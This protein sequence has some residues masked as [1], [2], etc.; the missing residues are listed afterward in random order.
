MKYLCLVYR[1]EKIVEA[2]SQ[3]EFAAFVG[4][5]SAY[6]AMLRESGHGILSQGLQSVQ[7]AT[8]VRVRSGK[9]YTTDGP[10]AETK[11]QLGGFSS[12]APGIWTKPSSWRPRSR[13]RAWGASR[14]GRSGR[15]SSRSRDPVGGIVGGRGS[16]V[17]GSLTDRS[18]LDKVWPSARPLP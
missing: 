13:R 15:S 16:S 3:A 4:E 9:V 6:D 17:S 12:S 18:R 5:H 7:T 8:T 10:F 2:M 1:E 14:S 11:E